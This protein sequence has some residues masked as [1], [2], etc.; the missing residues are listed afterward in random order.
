MALR[1]RILAAPDGGV[2]RPWPVELLAPKKA[3]VPWNLAIEAAVGV[4]GSFGIAVLTGHVA[5]GLLAGLG[6]LPLA[7]ADRNGPWR[8]RARRMIGAALAVGCGIVIG[9]AVRGHGVEVVA[10]GALVAAVSGLVSGFDAT[11]SIF[12]LN[13]LVYVAIAGIDPLPGP[14]WR[15]ALIAMAGAGFKLVISLADRLRPGPAHER[16]TVAAVYD[17]IAALLEGADRPDR[18]DRRWALTTALNAAEDAMVVLR[19]SLG[20]PMRQSADL[21]VALDSSLPLARAAIDRLAGGEPA[22][23]QSVAAVR[24]VAEAVRDG[25]P[26]RALPP[27]DAD[28]VEAW[29]VARRGVG[30]APAADVATGLRAVRE[31]WAARLARASGRRSLVA[32][33]RLTVCFTLAEAVA[34]WGPDARPYWV[35]LT[36]AVAMKPDF[37]SVFAR[38]V[39]RAVGTSVGVVVGGLIL[40]AVSSPRE[41]LPAFVVLSALLPV[42]VLRNYGM[43]VTCL[44]PLVLIQI[45]SITPSPGQLITARLLNTLLGVGIV[46]V[47][48]FAVWPSTWRPALAADLAAALA[49][50][51]ACVREAASAAPGAAG[52]RRAAYRALSDLRTTWSQHFADPSPTGRQARL[53]WPAL[54]ALERLI[55]EVA[56]VTDAAAGAAGPLRADLEAVAGALDALAAGGTGAS[57]ASPPTDPG[58]ALAWDRVAEVAGAIDRARAEPLRPA[59]LLAGLLHL[60]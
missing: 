21:L 56:R 1:S 22:G 4:G 52:R 2:G 37:G 26:V 13:L 60:R 49:A 58:A 7:G 8:M 45:D 11:W 38:A 46:L 3:P 31:L 5:A 12:G 9:A 41:L 53:L 54:I 50:V 23:P 10:V 16:R 57:P 33:L 28:V 55:D 51:A 39:Q 59:H 18:Y 35:P 42:A 40:L 43:F 19:T 32:T 6:A 34:L 47:A 48:G 14:A 20:G 17:A 36:V 29:S 27:S 44:T 15:T 25:G 24:A 30:S